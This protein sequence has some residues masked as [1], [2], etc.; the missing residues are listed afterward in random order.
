M[1]APAGVTCVCTCGE[2]CSTL[3]LPCPFPP[4]ACTPAGPPSPGITGG[5]TITMVPPGPPPPGPPN[6]PK[7]CGPG[8]GNWSSCAEAVRRPRPALFTPTVTLLLGSKQESHGG[9]EQRR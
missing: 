7:P 2:V 5:S 4:A 1:L 9:G 3:V 6:P 8:L